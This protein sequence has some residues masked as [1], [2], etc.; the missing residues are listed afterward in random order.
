M[1]LG[2]TNRYI[3]Q[4]AFDGLIKIERVSSNRCVYHITPHGLAKKAKLMTFYLR[5]SLETFRQ[6]RSECVNF[7][8]KFSITPKVVVNIVGRGDFHDI[9]CLVAKSFSITVRI[10]DYLSPQDLISENNFWVI[11]DPERYKEIYDCL[12]S[13]IPEENILV[14][15]AFRFCYDQNK[16]VVCY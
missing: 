1:A 2:L 5:Q 8:S 4:C 12:I 6:A 9:A 11:S 3:K 14:F 15:E 7:F 13:L 16:E 10:F